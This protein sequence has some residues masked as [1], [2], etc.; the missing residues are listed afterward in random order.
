[1]PRFKN[2]YWK[3]ELEF[4]LSR[5]ISL[6][7]ACKYAQVPLST[8]Y[9]YDF[10]SNKKPTIKEHHKTIVEMRKQGKNLNEI[11]NAIG[12]GINSIFKYCKKQGIK[13]PRKS[14]IRY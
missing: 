12:Y 4:A 3:E 6:K 7:S 13:K 1:M 9:K 14:E 2:P 11:S 5:G 10:K 8:A